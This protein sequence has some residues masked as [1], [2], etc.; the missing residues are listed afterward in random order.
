MLGVSDLPLPPSPL[1]WSPCKCQFKITI[2]LWSRQLL[3][4]PE[5]Q[6]HIVTMVRSGHD[7]PGRD[8]LAATASRRS[9]V[10]VAGTPRCIVIH[11]LYRCFMSRFH[12]CCTSSLLRLYLDPRK[13]V[14]RKRKPEGAGGVGRGHVTAAATRLAAAWCSR[15]LVKAPTGRRK[16][17]GVG[18][19]CVL[20]GVHGVGGR[21]T[22][23]RKGK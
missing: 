13:A 23:V 11:R 20:V 22:S 7:T 21:N 1:N 12:G 17:M 3:S 6:R 4:P 18:E 16:G 15:G 14:S 2:P 19:P 5:P 8:L 10:P 9:G